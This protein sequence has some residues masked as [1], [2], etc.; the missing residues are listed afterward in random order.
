MKN[1]FS[2]LC[3]ES[4]G[5]HIF[6]YVT[7]EETYLNNIV[8]YI[9]SGIEQGDHILLIESERLL[10][11]LTQKLTAVLTPE[12]LTHL[13]TINNFDYYFSSGSFHP[14]AIFEYLSKTL[15]PFVENDISYRIW[16]HVEWSEK[17]A[18]LNLLEEFEKEADR[19]V[20]DQELCLVC[21]YDAVRVPDSLKTAL[22]KCHKYFLTEDEIIPS[23]LYENNLVNNK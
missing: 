22:L 20:N 3:K 7:E 16:A 12:E 19:L 13:H 6:Y 2:N 14:P 1:K 9:G 15:K 23:K 5:A 4:H 8:S 21:A 18:I 11:L 10:T 17:E